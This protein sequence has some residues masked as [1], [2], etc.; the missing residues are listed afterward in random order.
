MK[1][2]TAHQPIT[3]PASTWP[4]DVA[5]MRAAAAELLGENA[6]LPRYEDLE[7]MTSRLR[8][9]LML[10]I[11]EVEDVVSRLPMDDVPGR[12]A[13]A[14]VGEARRRLDT[15]AGVGL[16][17]AVKYAQNLARSVESLCS[18][19]ESLRSITFCGSCDQLIKAGDASRVYDKFSSSGGGATVHVHAVCPSERR[20]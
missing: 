5:T 10:L 8:G 17:S 1:E 3:A 2:I 20:H 16:V 11:P 19:L 9:H 18:H 13:V 14:G 6:Q 15:A 12:V 4:L 7:V